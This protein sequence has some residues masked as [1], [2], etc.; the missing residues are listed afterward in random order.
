MRILI[1][2]DEPAI[3]ESLQRILER[4]GYE[5]LLAENGLEALELWQQQRPDLICLDV[6][7]PGLDGYSVC[8]RIREQDKVVPILFI[9]A[10]TEVTD[11]VIGL[12]LGGDDY[13]RKP[14]VKH[15]LLA[16]IR[17]VVRKSEYADKDFSTDKDA[18]ERSFDFGLWTILPDELRATGM[19]GC[20]DLSP[21]E[22]SI[23][24]FFHN[25]VGK[26]VSRDE[27]LNACWGMNFFPESRMLDQQVSRLR[28]KL[29]DVDSLLIETVRGV[30]YRYDGTEN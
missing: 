30:G 1:A 23:V 7:M 12:E 21:K 3:L 13:I 2:E 18:S 9:S 6:M 26:A 4:E 25:H 29:G 27:L 20:I 22:L 5:L 14:F 15:E 17:A 16:R 8:R 19:E 28:K 11:V 10:K 24:Q